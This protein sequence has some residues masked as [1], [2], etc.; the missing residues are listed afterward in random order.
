MKPFLPA[1][2]HCAVSEAVNVAAPAF[3]EF[4]AL[5]GGAKSHT[6]LVTNLGGFPVYFEF[7][8]KDV[9]SDQSIDVNRALV[10]LAGQSRVF[11]ALGT[12][13]VAQTVDGPSRIHIV[14]GYGGI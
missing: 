9:N 2:Q 12:C 5:M 4:D 8:G 14:P 1:A 13:I 10:I 7:C 6:A 3:I 11:G